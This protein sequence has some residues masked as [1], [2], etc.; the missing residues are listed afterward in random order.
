MECVTV[1]QAAE[2][3]SRETGKPLYEAAYE[4]MLGVK[5]GE[6]ALETGAD[7][8]LAYVLGPGGAWLWSVAALTAAAAVLALYAEAPPLLYLRYVVGA[9]FVLFLPGYVIVEALYPKPSE[10]KP[11]E[12]LA[13][14]IGLSLAVV[15]LVGLLLNY[16][17][18]GIRLGPVVASLAALTAAAAA[19]AA[20]R[21]YRSERLAAACA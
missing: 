13:L 1:R 9:F 11:L 18:F 16:T 7:S 4:L 6:Y 3:L 14:S 8:F 21:K 20:Y 17:P 19:F 12:R 10:L 5:R 2:R 15:P